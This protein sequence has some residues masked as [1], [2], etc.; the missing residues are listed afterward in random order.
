[1]II[2]ALLG[3]SLVIYSS[4]KFHA[5]HLDSGSVI[6]IENLAITDISLILIAYVPKIVTLV[7]G[8]WVLGG[9]ICYITAFGQ[10]MP[11]AT[12]II[13]LTLISAYRCYLIK[14]PFRANPTV[15]LTK[16]LIGVTW[17]AAATA[18]AI[19]VLSNKSTAIFDVRTLACV[20][21]V[22]RHHRIIVLASLI[23]FGIIPVTLTILF[24]V[25]LLVCAFTMK[26]RG[27]TF[28]TNAIVTVSLICWV[29]IL[30][31][32]P[33]IVRA[34]M[35]L[36]RPL[37]SWFYIVQYKLNIL[38]LTLNPIIY[39]FTN[40]KFRIFIQRRLMRAKLHFRYLW[41]FLLAPCFSS[42]ANIG[43]N[44]FVDSKTPKPD[45]KLVK[46]GRLNIQSARILK[47]SRVSFI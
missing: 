31:W 25:Y 39:T 24:N 12:E 38:S 4:S 28:N 3:N 10:F 7:A 5:I 11:G 45:L 6:L 41:S 15:W 37:P 2:T 9:V 23:F 44:G 21:D 26:R 8:R 29:F 35:A 20:T 40:R 32:M 19:F 47:H 36:S 16:V 33:Y 43:S 34:L 1:M 42:H 17:L 18:P 22:A 13:T 27:K 14:Y 30:S 46:F